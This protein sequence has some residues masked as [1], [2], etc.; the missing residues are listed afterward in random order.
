MLL[1]FMAIWYILWI[2]GNLGVIVISRFGI[3]YQQKSGNPGDHGL[4]I[5]APLE[6]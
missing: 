1:N 5:G 2:F 3:S 4:Y 6:R